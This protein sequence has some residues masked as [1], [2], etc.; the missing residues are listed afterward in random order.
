M[1]QHAT[2][3]ASPVHMLGFINLQLLVAIYISIRIRGIIHLLRSGLVDLLRSISSGHFELAI[4]SVTNEREVGRHYMRG[5]ATCICTYQSRINGAWRRATVVRPGDEALEAT[6]TC[7]VLSR[8][9]TEK[10][11]G[12]QNM[13]TCNTPE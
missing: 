8:A 7:G 2:E 10:L 11:P 5:V 9:A 6:V 4:S 13:I 3:L 12:R 1:H